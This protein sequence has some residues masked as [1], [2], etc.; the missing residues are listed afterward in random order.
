VRVRAAALLALGD[1][2]DRRALPALCE[3]LAHDGAGMAREAAAQSLSRIGDRSVERALET[4]AES[5]GKSKVRKAARDALEQIRARS[6]R[7]GY[8]GHDGANG[9]AKPSS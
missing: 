5:D 3:R 6:P 4:A 2:G 8:R 1:L 7:P 9:G